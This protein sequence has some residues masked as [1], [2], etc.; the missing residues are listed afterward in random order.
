[1]FSST[2]APQQNVHWNTLQ[3]VNGQ[4][5]S[6]GQEDRSLFGQSGCGF[7]LPQPLVQTVNFA[8][9]ARTG[10]DAIIRK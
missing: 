7:I 8:A 1:M 9:A 3:Q 6:F 2:S 5:F 10:C 4:L